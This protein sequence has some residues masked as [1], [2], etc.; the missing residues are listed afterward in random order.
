MKINSLHEGGYS[1]AKQPGC[2]GVYRKDDNCIVY[3]TIHAT[4]SCNQ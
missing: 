1:S 3:L 4:N 2:R